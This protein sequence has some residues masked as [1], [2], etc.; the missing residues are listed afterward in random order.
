M[1][2]IMNSNNSISRQKQKLDIAKKQDNTGIFAMLRT[3]AY[4][5]VASCVIEHVIYNTQLPETARLL[6]VLV[7]AHA[8][9]IWQ[10]TGKRMVEKSGKMW[11]QLLGEKRDAYVYQ[12]QQKLEAAG[13][14]HIT[15]KKINAQN[16]INQLTP[17]LP[18]VVFNQL[19]KTAKTR[20]PHAVVEGQV[21]N[22]SYEEQRILLDQCKL[23]TP[24]HLPTVKY[25][26]NNQSLSPLQKL[27][28]IHCFLR[29]S[30]QQQACAVSSG[31]FYTTLKELAQAFSCHT[32]SI[33]RALENL[34]QQQLLTVQQVYCK[35]EMAN[36]NRRDKSMWEIELICPPLLEKQL[37]AA[38]NRQQRVQSTRPTATITTTE[39]KAA[40]SNYA[41]LATTVTPQLKSIAQ[42][43]YASAD[44]SVI[45]IKDLITKIKNFR[46]LAIQSPSTSKKVFFTQNQ[47]KVELLQLASTTEVTQ[48]IEQYQYLIDQGISAFQ[49]K[50]WCAKKLSDETRIVLTKQAYNLYQADISMRKQQADPTKQQYAYTPFEQALLQ[51]ICLPAYRV[52]IDEQSLQQ[53]MEPLPKQCN[54]Q[55]ALHN[56]TQGAV[57]ATTS[58][59]QEKEAGMQSV[60][61]WDRVGDS[62]IKKIKYWVHRLRKENNIRGTARMYSDGELISQ[63]A[64]HTKHWQPKIICYNRSNFAIYIACKRLREGTWVQPYGIPL[65]RE[66]AWEKEKKFMAVN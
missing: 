40:S 23:F 25:L 11:G 12:L 3:K 7:D 24:V 44:T 53:L 36:S 60:E 65:A 28:W 18:D 39:V 57:T 42:R 50:Q 22:N 15:R 43:S 1:E 20:Q 61:A 30:W 45:N 34:Q 52:L 6:Y 62:I 37:Q 16:E 27:I 56:Y 14:L 35:T 48:C 41:Q 29:A 66:L 63:I 31:K 19:M 51:E 9:L 49:A 38:N 46:E 13:Y 8:H 2:I 10:T 33:S 26:L 59:S 17:Q 21:T 58:P 64:F 4:I 55:Y 5:P 32:S 47:E 54:Q